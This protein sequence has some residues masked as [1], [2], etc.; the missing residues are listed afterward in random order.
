M[1]SGKWTGTTG[2]HSFE[3]VYGE[4]CE[5]PAVLETSLPVVPTVAVL[6]CTPDPNNP[7]QCLLTPA[8]TGLVD[9]DPKQEGGA[10]L[11]SCDN[12]ATSSTGTGTGIING[13]V[14]LSGQTCSFMSPCEITG[15]LTVDGG[16]VYLNCTLDGNL[17][18]TAGTLNLGPS[19]HLHGNVNISQAS[20]FNIGPNVEIDGNLQIQTASGP[21]ALCGTQVK[22]NVT[23]Q[24]N[25][26]I[27][28]VTPIQ[29]GEPIGQMPMICPGNKIGGNLTCAGNTPKPIS[30]SNTLGGHNNCTG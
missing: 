26:N 1:T 28:T 30:G 16:T 21:G 18:M 9:A 13:N 15:N 3:L 14:T 4:C 12:G 22:G 7:G 29:I 24:N 6:P 2:T 25:N 5:L 23:V 11:L 27:L 17:T 10:N 8:E 20:A 19:A